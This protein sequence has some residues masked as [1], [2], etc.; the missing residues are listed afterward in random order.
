LLVSLFDG[1]VFFSFAD[2]FF[3]SL[4]GGFMCILAVTTYFSSAASASAS[5]S[6][7]FYHPNFFVCFLDGWNGMAW[8][9]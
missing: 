1:W 5:A 2:F 8:D 3:Y 9:G 6:A 7:S 4:V